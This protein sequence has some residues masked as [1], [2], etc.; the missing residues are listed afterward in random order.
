MSENLFSYGTL[1]KNNVQL[2]LFGRLLT[3]TKDSLQGYKLASIEIKDE[4]FLA[5]G[6]DKFQR[7]LIPSKDDSDIIEGTVLEIS[8]AEL[9][10][11]DKYEPDNYKRIE[12]ELQSGTKAW[13]YIAAEMT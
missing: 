8:E 10:L 13:I 3:G 4:S 9:L 1:Q 7:T 11:A 6:E 2:E 5:K 12:I